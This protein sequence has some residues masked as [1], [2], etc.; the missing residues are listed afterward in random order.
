M[1]AAGG[2]H[3]AGGGAALRRRSDLQSFWYDE[4]FTPVHVL[5][6][7]LG[8]T[9]RAVS[10]TENTPPLWYVLMWG[11]SRVWGTG[12]VALRSLSALA[13]VWHRAG[14]VGDRAGAGR[15]PCGARH[16]GARR[17]EPAVRVVLPGGSRLRA[18]HAADG[19]G[20]AV[21]P[22]RSA[23]AHV[24]APG[25]LRVAGALALLDPLLRGLPAGADVCLAARGWLSRSAPRVRGHRGGGGRGLGSGLL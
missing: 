21:L 7:G 15:S 4:A 19:A 5:H 10:H 24:Q 6:A 18:L 9:L 16:R 13:G 20:D 14:G 22:A 11:W 25:G 3:A 23:R 8:A 17:R 12:E 1:V 2:S